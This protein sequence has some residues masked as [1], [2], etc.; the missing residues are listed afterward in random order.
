M[1]KKI[2]AITGA[3]DGIGLATAKQLALKGH[4][5]L[6]HGRNA[7]KLEQ[8]KKQLEMLGSQSQIDTYIADFSVMSDV[9]SFA[10]VIAEQ[11]DTLD[12][13]MNNAGVFRTS[14]PVTSEGFDVRFAVNTFAPY[15]LTKLLL[16]LMNA[17]SR[18]INLSS[19]AQAPI[20]YKILSGDQLA[21]DEFA[22][23]AQSKLALT[24]WSCSMGRSFKVLSATDPLPV[25]IAVNP[26][27]MLGSKMVKEGFGVAGGDIAVGADI[28]NRIALGNEFANAS[29]LYFDNDTRQ[30]ASPHADALD[31]KKCEVLLETMESILSE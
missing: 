21:V 12:V 2:I 11:H 10:Q 17:S 25:V 27:S 22:T 31:A 5:L 18:V 6:L 19:A 23:Y 24:M 28:L 8:V 7:A 13:L 3:T 26:G 9:V 29:G 16:P 14:E 20:D 15:L 1:D 4:H 30:L